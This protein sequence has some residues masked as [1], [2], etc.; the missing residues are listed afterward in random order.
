MRYTGLLFGIVAMLAFIGCSDDPVSSTPE[1]AISS[2]S[3]KLTISAGMAGGSRGQMPP[4]RMFPQGV[5]TYDGITSAAL[6]G[7]LLGDPAT[8]KMAIYLPPSY[9]MMP[10]KRYPTVYLLHGYLG[11]HETFPWSMNAFMQGVGLDLGLDI[12]TI[13]DELISSGQMEEMIIVMPEGGTAYGG[14]WYANSPVIGNF[15]DYIAEEV[16][17]YI[18]GK[19]RT[20]DS[21]DSRG[22]SGHSMGGYGSLSLAMEYHEVFGGVAAMSPGFPNDFG[23]SPTPI[24][25]FLVENPEILGEPILVDMTQETLDLFPVAGVIFSTNFST[26][27][28]YAMASAF[29][30]NPDKPP[31]YVDLP[32]EYPG[33]TVVEEV[34]EKWVEQDL[35]HQIARDGANLANTA[36]FVN[37]GVGPTIVMEEVPNVDLLIAALGD[38]GLTYTYEEVDG[39]HIT[40][41]REQVSAV[42]KFLSANME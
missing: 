22:I 9:G 20:I 12:R 36:I 11:G 16:V 39:D 10:E 32:I 42:L 3:S 30:P 7:N 38:A 29:S 13:A 4:A 21:R 25:G 23:V 26:N 37:Q 2:P 35:V 6:E 17:A 40:H 19:Y 34:W 1:E 31:F 15:R 33:K 5:L 18:D 8:R 28:F 24:D 14:S 27:V 41:L